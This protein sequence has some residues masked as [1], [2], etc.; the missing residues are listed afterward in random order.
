MRPITFEPDAVLRA[1]TYLF[2]EKGYAGTSLDDIM[3]VAHI[4]KQS[5]YNFFGDKKSL[6]LK[7]LHFYFEDTMVVVREILSEKKAAPD[8]LQQMFQYFLNR[9]DIGPYPD[10]CL[11]VNTMSEFGKSDPSITT[12][13]D[14]MEKEFE[15]ILKKT[16]VL[17]QKE[18]TITYKIKATD[19]TAY[20][21]CILCGI[22]L[23]E[24][25]GNRGQEICS[26]PHQAVRSVCR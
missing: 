22:L 5:L 15:K 24:R 2:W 10:G 21:K 25:Q 19:I 8:L 3:E 14:G 16:V 17:G 11:I 26:I 23:L 1:A 20:L 12:I 9:S 18:G 13:I 7:V 4:Q 6:F